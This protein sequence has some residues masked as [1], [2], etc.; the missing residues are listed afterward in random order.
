MRLVAAVLSILGMLLLIGFFPVVSLFA[1]ILGPGP[2]L[3]VVIVMITLG[4]FCFRGLA[5]GLLGRSEPD[6]VIVQHPL[7]REEPP[8]AATHSDRFERL[9]RLGNLREQGI[10]TDAEYS[11]EK[12][13]LLGSGR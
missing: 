7:G 4:V 12:A 11:R 2:I 5:F 10:L 3:V 9:E 1:P 6:V 8:A 13:I